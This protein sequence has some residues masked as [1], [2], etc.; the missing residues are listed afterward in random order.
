MNF[1]SKQDTIYI[2]YACMT[3]FEYESLSKL[4]QKAYI[5]IRIY[6]SGCPFHVWA[7]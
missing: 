4:R 2:M 1:N 7:V 5:L 6:R 3:S